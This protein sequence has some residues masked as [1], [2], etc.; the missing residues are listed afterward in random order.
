MIRYPHF[1]LFL[2]IALF[3]GLCFSACK[4]DDLPIG[5]PGTFSC[6]IDGEEWTPASPSEWH[7]FPMQFQYYPEIGGI[8]FWASNRPEN[9][10]VNQSLTFSAEKVV[11]GTNYIDNTMGALLDWKVELDDCGTY[12]VD[13]TQS[14]NNW[15]NIT[16]LD[17]NSRTIQ[18]T[19]NFTVVN[20]SEECD[21]RVRKVTDG[22]FNFTY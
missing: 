3:G 15:I 2:L 7:R 11:K 10:S 1:R 18:G 17:P 12:D 6:R 8:S 21:D 13:T 5:H 16:C 20:R 22:Q 14:Q 4:D 19:F 9:G